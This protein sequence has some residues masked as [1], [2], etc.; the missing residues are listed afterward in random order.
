MIQ[1]YYQDG[2]PHRCYNQHFLYYFLLSI[3]YRS[4]LFLKTNRYW[5]IE[6]YNYILEC[7]RIKWVLPL[8]LHCQTLQ[9]TPY[10]PKWQRVSVLVVL[11][12]SSWEHMSSCVVVSLAIELLVDINILPQGTVQVWHLGYHSFPFL[13]CSPR[14]PFINQYDMEDE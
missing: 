3:F 13:G 4:N 12:N 5:Y 1:Q 8:S 2:N 9:S 11:C 14:Y 6:K 10:C 7:K